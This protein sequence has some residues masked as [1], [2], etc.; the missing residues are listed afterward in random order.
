[1]ENDSRDRMAGL[2]HEEKKFKMT[3]PAFDM[4]EWIRLRISLVMPEKHVG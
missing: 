1:M 2:G 4:T 3:H